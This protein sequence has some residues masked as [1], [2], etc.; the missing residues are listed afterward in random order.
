MRLRDRRIQATYPVRLTCQ[1]VGWPPPDIVWYKD[2]NEISAENGKYLRAWN[3][4]ACVRACLSEDCLFFL[5][6]RIRFTGRYVILNDGQFNTLEIIRATLDDC[7]TY[8]ATA[9]NEHG[10][11]SCHCSLVVDKGIRAY[12]APEFLCSLDTE[13]SVREGEELLLTAQIEAYPAVGVTWNRNGVRL[14]PSRRIIFTL[15]NDGFVELVISNATLADAGVYKCIASN[16][17]GRSECSCKV[18]ITSEQCD[19]RNGG[20]AVPIIC[21]PNMPYSKEPL[22]VKKPRSFDAFEGDTVIIDCEVIGDPK[23]EIV[24]LRDFL[25]VSRHTMM[26]PSHPLIPYN[27]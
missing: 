6:L 3:L 23:P 13:H 21:E 2:S 25:K 15:D 10:S 11:V 4:Y 19:S 9:R 27:Y 20:L 12:I 16:A 26:P 17:V 1:A 8:T 5:I 22:F 7:G 24:W 14:R 18:I